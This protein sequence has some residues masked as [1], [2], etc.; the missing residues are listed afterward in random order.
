MSVKEIHCKS[1]SE[2]YGQNVTSEGSMYKTVVLRDGQTN[3]HEKQ[4]SGWPAIL[5]NVL[6]EKFAKDESSQ[7]QNLHENFQK[8]HSLFPARLSL[9]S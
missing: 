1:C 3:V 9:L 8:F 7:F 5:F 4:R 2:V 6:T